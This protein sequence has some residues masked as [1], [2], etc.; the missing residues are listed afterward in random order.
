VVAGCA[1]VRGHLAG[2][3]LL[4]EREGVEIEL[5]RCSSRLGTWGPWRPGPVVAG[6]DGR[7]D[8]GGDR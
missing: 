6:S 8:P 5:H 4:F 7:V 2:S 3:L 1:T